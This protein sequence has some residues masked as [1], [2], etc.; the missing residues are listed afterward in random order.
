MAESVDLLPLA[1]V[2]ERLNISKATLWRWVKDGKLKTVK[3]S[4]RK[5]YIRREELDRFIKESE[6]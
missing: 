1:E 5:V 3:L 2:R 4:E 6:G